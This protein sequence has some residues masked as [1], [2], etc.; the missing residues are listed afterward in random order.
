[1]YKNIKKSQH[2][3]KIIKRFD[4]D[5]WGR[6]ALINKPT[7]VLDS[8][9]QIYQNNIKYKKLIYKRRFFSGKNTNLFVY[10]AVTEEKE[11]K[12]KRRTIKINN[13]LSM[14]KLRRFYGSLGKRKFKRIFKQNSINTNVVGRSF[15]YF[16]ESR[17]DVILYRANLFKSIFAARQYINHKKVYV[18]GSVVTKP[19]YLVFINDIITVSNSKKFYSDLKLNLTTDDLLSNVPSY[20]EVNYKLG[21]VILVKMPLT[22][23]V[24][25]PFFMDLKTVVHN[26]FR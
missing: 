8:I 5:I 6:L 13:Y 18:N 21:S 1:M 24:P 22:T 10:K 20:L 4:E 17:L 15:S 26:F 19:G 9:F 16:L 25:F 12:R 7:R 3:L 14:L 11:L 2:S 23:E